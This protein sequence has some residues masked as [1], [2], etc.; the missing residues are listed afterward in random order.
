MTLQLA[1]QINRLPECAPLG[2]EEQYLRRL[3]LDNFFRCC[4]VREF[5][6]SVL[7]I[8]KSKLHAPHNDIMKERLDKQ[9]K[10]YMRYNLN[11]PYDRA[12]F[13][14]H[15][16][17][18]RPPCFSSLPYYLDDSTRHDPYLLSLCKTKGGKV[19]KC[20]LDR[21]IYWVS[22]YTHVIYNYLYNTKDY[23]TDLKPYADKILRIGYYRFIESRD[24]TKKT[25]ERFSREAIK[26]VLDAL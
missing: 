25:E 9:Y 14:D 22:F 5:Q 26:E 4:R 16:F 6:K 3:F 11:C 12:D 20:R 8:L 7:W 10:I 24:L 23:A 13:F 1:N 19:I 15:R 21:V 2:Y 18:R 17:Q